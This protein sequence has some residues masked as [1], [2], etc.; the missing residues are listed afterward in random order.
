MRTPPAD[1]IDA[2][3]N[4]QAAYGVPASVAIAQWA[5]E[6]AW[7]AHCTG[8]YNFFGV[9]ATATQPASLCW[10][11]EVVG[12]KS[13]ACQQRFA[14]YVSLKAAFGAHAALLTHRQYAKAWPFKT[15]EAFVSAIAPVYATDPD[16]G[17]KLMT[18]IRGNRLER[19]DVAP[20]AA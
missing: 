8:K 16:Y 15:V 11:H 10:T 14:D 7:G 13:V 6:S 1:V 20:V 5:L 12:G 18:I 9:K 17:E 2:A 4:A 3:Q 19:Y